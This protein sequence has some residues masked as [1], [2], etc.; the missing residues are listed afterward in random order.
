MQETDYHCTE[1]ERERT[2]EA[3]PRATVASVQLDQT[4]SLPWVATL[5]GRPVLPSTV[6]QWLRVPM[7]E[8][9]LIGGPG[10]AV[11]FPLE[12]VIG[13][14]ANLVDRGRYGSN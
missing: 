4:P 11:Q 12:R 7:N 10:Q 14:E 8:K 2:K 13:K 9:Y 6:T 1:R 3:K 5:R